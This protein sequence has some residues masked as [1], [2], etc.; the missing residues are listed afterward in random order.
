VLALSVASVRLRKKAAAP[1]EIALVLGVLVFRVFAVRLGEAFLVALGVAPSVVAVL[2]FLA[3]AVRVGEA[4]LLV[5]GVA[6]SAVVESNAAWSQPERI[7]ASIKKQAMKSGRTRLLVL[8]ISP[9][10][11]SRFIAPIPYYFMT[12][13]KKVGI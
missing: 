13:L 7:R 10:Q 4:F 3:P 2:A 9:L 1:L 6:L 12:P 5:L 11:K 8:F